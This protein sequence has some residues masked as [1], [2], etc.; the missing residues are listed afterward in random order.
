MK[1]K[2][3]FVAGPVVLGVLL[4]ACGSSPQAE[5]KTVFHMPTTSKTTMTFP[6]LRS[7]TTTSP[8]SSSNSNS[9]PQPYIPIPTTT[10]TA[11]PTVTGDYWTNCG[12]WR[13][14]IALSDGTVKLALADLTGKGYGTF[15]FTYDDYSHISLPIPLTISYT[16]NGSTCSP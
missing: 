12:A 5:P 11:A 14:S 3:S 8:Q 9:A 1:F 16:D 15:T 10:T 4:T 2:S 6:Y 13:Y 7:T